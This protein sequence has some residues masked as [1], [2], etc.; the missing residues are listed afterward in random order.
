M[1]LPCW[2]MLSDA[3]PPHT[4]S[5]LERTL[6]TRPSRPAGSLKGRTQRTD[7]V[8]MLGNEHALLSLFADPA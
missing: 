6:R 4:R 3:Q 2:G 8:S 1:R 7:T 5:P